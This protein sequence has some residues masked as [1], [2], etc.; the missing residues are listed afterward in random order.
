MNS[1]MKDMAEAIVYRGLLKTS[2]QAQPVVP[3]GGAPVHVPPPE[4][5]SG[6]GGTGAGGPTATAARSRALGIGAVAGR[7]TNRAVTSRRGVG[8]NNSEED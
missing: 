4:N 6:G 1:D 2:L 3:V 5:P 8:Q 7:G